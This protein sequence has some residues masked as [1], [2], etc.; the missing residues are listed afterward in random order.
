MA[1]KQ[2]NCFEYLEKT[3]PSA[4]FPLLMS[5]GSNIVFCWMYCVVVDIRSLLRAQSCVQLSNESSRQRQ[6]QSVT[7]YLLPPHKTRLI[8]TSA[9]LE[10]SHFM[11]STKSCELLLLPLKAR[12]RSWRARGIRC[13]PGTDSS[14]APGHT[15]ELSET[16]G[17]QARL[18]KV[19]TKCR[20]NFHKIDGNLNTESPLEIGMLVHKDHH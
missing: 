13:S 17:S 4:L 1:S 19:P 6:G 5:I 8:K 2:I 12:S 14:L 7:R 9:G 20:G 16:A 18:L 3:R 11:F 15:P 10:I